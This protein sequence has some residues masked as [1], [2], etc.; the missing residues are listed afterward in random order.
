MCTSGLKKYPAYDE[1]LKYNFSNS[2]KKRIPI[3]S[4]FLT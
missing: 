2:K 4:S 1:L 3:Q